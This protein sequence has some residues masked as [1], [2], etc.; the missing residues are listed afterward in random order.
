[1]SALIEIVAGFATVR[2]LFC[3]R[4]VTGR[5]EGDL[6][7]GDGKGTA[8]LALRAPGT[9]FFADFLQPAAGGGFKIEF[10]KKKKKHFRIF[11]LV[12]R[13]KWLGTGKRGTGGPSGH[14]PRT[15]AE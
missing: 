5:A 10:P 4:L 12:L 2:S 15:S 9:H 3:F 11:I 6:Y 8:P 7:F 13:R 14:L 1:M